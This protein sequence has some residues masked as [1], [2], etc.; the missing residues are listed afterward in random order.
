MTNNTPESIS[1]NN[2]ITAL[3]Q[4]IIDSIYERKGYAVTLLDLSDIEGAAAPEFIICQGNSPTQV[5]A[6]ADNIRE[7]LLEKL[8]RKPF[9]YDGYRNSEWIVIDYGDIL[10]HIFRKDIREHYNLEELWSD[11]KVTRLPDEE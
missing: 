5:S 8:G 9:N 11:A 7:E 3:R 2:V 6:I 1:T 10:V 4:Q